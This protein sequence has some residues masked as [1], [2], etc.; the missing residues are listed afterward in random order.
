MTRT[1]ISIQLIVNLVF[2]ILVLLAV[3]RYMKYAN[4][5]IDIGAWGVFYTVFGVLYAIIIGFILISA[6]GKFDQ[7]KLAV[8]SEVSEI[9]SIRILLQYF[10]DNQIEAINN[11]RKTLF[12]Y[13][14]SI[15]SIEW[16][17]MIKK[18]SQ[19]EFSEELRNV[20]DSVS[21]LKS[22]DENDSIALT[23][24]IN[25][26]SGLTACRTKRIYLANEEIPGPI[27]KLLIFMSCVMVGGFIILGVENF[28]IHLFM[29]WSLSTTVHL[30]I[31]LLNDL[32]NPFIGIWL[33]EKNHYF[34]IVKSI[35]KN[36]IKD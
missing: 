35:D 7:L 4:I 17:D 19:P 9:Q 32:N 23:S 1:T 27:M 24:I 20:R 28:W 26:L 29:I 6:L 15:H 22:E 18:D 16:E 25:T 2:G 3:R 21:H 34:G 8:D 31:T 33:I 5:T 10:S 30:I 13:V 36:I 14:H 12:A 11:I